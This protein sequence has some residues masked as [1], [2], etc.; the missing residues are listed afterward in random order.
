MYY[1]SNAACP[2]QV[3]QRIELFVSR[4]AM[5]IR[6][7]G[8]N[9][10]ATLFQ[11]GLATDSADL[12]YLKDKKEQLLELEK[13][14]E[15]STINMLDAI[16][17]S[18]DRPLAR[19]I[20]ALG[21]RHIGEETAELLAREFHSIDALAEASHE[22]L[23]SIETI[24]PKIADSII[25]F[26]HEDANRDIIKRLREAGVKLEEKPAEAEALPLSG[27][28]FVLTGTLEAFSRKEAE[29]RIKTLGGTAGSNVSRKTTYLVAGADPGAKL[30]KAR[31]LGT[32]ILNEAEFL[33]L[34]NQK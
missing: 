24:G 7:I 8:E 18:K 12:Y 21:I 4:G 33:K 1:C 28:E 10:S 34:L 23:I 11:E 26:F 2:A 32:K 30:D 29:E 20:L 14:G 13:M 16:E 22:E 17:K 19:V 27:M 6:G 5:D 15:Q 9:L 25:A 31:S 3:Q